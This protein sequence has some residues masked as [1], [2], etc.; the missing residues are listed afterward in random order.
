MLVDS[1]CHLDRVDL[2]PFAGDLARLRTEVRRYR[3]RHLLCVCINLET[4]PAM[5]GWLEDWPEV[6]IS[7]GVHPSETAG[8]E[9]GEDE[10]MRLAQHPRNVAIGETGLDY[11]WVK[12]DR[13]WQRERFRRHIRAARAAGRPLIVHT[14]EA[15]RDTL[16]ILRE[17]D[18]A[19]A[20]GV[21]H[22][23]T[24]DWDMARAAMDLGFYISFSGI[25][26]FRNAHAVQEVARK[27]PFDRLL[28]ETDS[29]YLTPAPL[30]GKPNNPANVRFVARYLAQLRGVSVEY[31]AQVT[32]ANF[33]SLFGAHRCGGGESNRAQDVCSD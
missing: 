7:V 32:T 18:A 26:T 6:S 25:V 21:M 22:C 33:F 14:R 31:L 30:R 24:E 3:V 5:L 23:F 20:G 2:E 16:C 17:E 10:L 15:R 1:H 29:P 19:S 11:H 9:P 27:V 8:R 12:G 4:Y 28:I 13:T